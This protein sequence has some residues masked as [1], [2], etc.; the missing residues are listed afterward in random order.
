[1]VLLANGANHEVSVKQS[2]VLTTSTLRIL[3]VWMAMACLAACGGPVERVD[4]GDGGAT[5]QAAEA[6][7]VLVVSLTGKLGTT[8]LARCHRALRVACND[9][10]VGLPEP[11]VCSSARFQ[12]KNV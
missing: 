1:M 6:P 9:R 8:E 5:E 11:C 12:K 10:N 4:W 7:Q 3:W 2:T